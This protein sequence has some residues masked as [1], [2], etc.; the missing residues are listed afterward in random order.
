MS[1]DT[2]R[3]RKVY[4]RVNSMWYAPAMKSYITLLATSLVFTLGQFAT[5]CSVPVFRYALENWEP[6]QLTVAVLHKGPLSEEH[7]SL[8]V[9]MEAATEADEQVNLRIHPI[10]VAVEH[11]EGSAEAFHASQWRDEPLPQLLV[12]FTNDAPQPQLAWSGPMN[13]PNVAGLLASPARQQ[14][15]ETVAGWPVSG[16][17]VVEEWQTGRRR[18]CGERVIT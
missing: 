1:P 15:V 9:Q 18:A 11:P 13:E 10:D 12:Y 6:D 4:A 16:L 2:A 3:G 14:V 17:G 8:V 7:Q 5:A